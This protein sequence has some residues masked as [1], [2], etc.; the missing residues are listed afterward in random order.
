MRNNDAQIGGLQTDVVMNAALDWFVHKQSGVPDPALDIGFENWISSDPAHAAAYAELAGVW[1]EPELFSA[2][3]R[4]ARQID[5]RAVKP[6]FSVLGRKRAHWLSLSAAV[7]LFVGGYAAYPEIMVR[8][9]ADYR[10]V[11]GQMQNVILPD[12]SRMLLNTDSAV[13]LAYQGQQ[14][15]VRL[16]KGEAWFDVVHDASRP[17]RVAGHF[18]DVTVKGTAFVVRAEANR[19]VV[20]LER[21]RVDV[22]RDGSAQTA[23][24]LL[25][26]QMV[27]VDEKSISDIEPF[28][29]DEML[30][31]REGRIAFSGKPL[32]AVLGDLARYYDGRVFVLR[33]DLLSVAVSGNYR[34]DDAAGAIGSIVTAVGGKIDTLPGNF[35]IIR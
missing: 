4:H 11:A 28:E 32:G 14:R 26:D 5:L 27:A 19:D 1:H 20:A 3:Q 7:V 10:T 8:W 21:G 6:A 15:G 25:P 13:E 35:I 24:Q 2:S 22:I 23:V 34:T 31:W 16:L 30:A 29:P 33:R 18:G 17:F 9:S 12:G